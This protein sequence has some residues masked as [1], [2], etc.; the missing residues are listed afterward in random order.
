MIY[1]TYS[2]KSKL[3]ILAAAQP[4]RKSPQKP[5]A[6]CP[7]I[8]EPVLPKSP[9]K[10]P[11]TMKQNIEDSA[12]LRRLQL[13]EAGRIGLEESPS[14]PQNQA[15][16]ERRKEMEMLSNRWNRNKEMAV[17]EP[18][19]PKPKS[20]TTPLKTSHIA[21]CKIFFSYL[22]CLSQFG[23]KCLFFSSLRY[24][25]LLHHPLH[26]QVLLLL[27]QPR[28]LLLPDVRLADLR[29][30]SLQQIYHI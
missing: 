25:A 9:S 16:A 24:Q 21:V 18:A 20:H 11:S 8:K 17:D 7:P 4:A 27:P 10:V 2:H 15:V 29:L 14:R 22:F 13:F 6:A 23:L 3:C 12:V 1:K 28:E 30:V 26:C 19:S 5:T